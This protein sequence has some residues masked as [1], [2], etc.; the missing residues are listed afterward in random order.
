M[1]SEQELSA[2]FGV[3]RITV[4]QALGDLAREGRVLRVPGKG[5]FFSEPRKAEPQSALT[6]FSEN[7][8]AL[9]LM[10]SYLTLN[11]RQLRP[12][13]EVAEALEIDRDSVILRFKRLLLADGTPMAVM[14]A[15]FPSYVFAEAP[16][17]FEPARLDATSLYS[18][19]EN[20]LGIS[21]WKARETVE[22]GTAGADAELLDLTSE[23]LVLV[24]HRRTLDSSG[25]PVEYTELRYRADLYR[26]NVELFRH[27]TRER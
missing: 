15:H 6:S 10:P 25:R 23:D 1:T 5:T 2:E 9:G 4:R 20:E 7:M 26:Y 13:S 12:N 11:S 19:L 24:V 16:H 14:R 3:S 17:L 22:A 8:A 18:T 27:G 21:L